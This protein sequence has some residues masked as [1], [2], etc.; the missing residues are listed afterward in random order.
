MS[1]LYN[2]NNNIISK[3]DDEIALD[4]IYFLECRV[5]TKEDLTKYD[6]K[7]QQMK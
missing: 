6:K 4:K 7:I 3:Y 5:P 2:I 1:Y